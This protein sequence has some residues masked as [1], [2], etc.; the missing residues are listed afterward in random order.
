MVGREPSCVRTLILMNT[1]L[2]AKS[3]G[4]VP[5]PLRFLLNP[6]VAPLQARLKQYDSIRSIPNLPM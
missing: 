6:L 4:D 2:D 1:P 3:A 5:P